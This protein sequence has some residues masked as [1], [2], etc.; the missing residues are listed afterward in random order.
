MSNNLEQIIL[1]LRQ[2]IWRQGGDF[3]ICRD[4]IHTNPEAARAVAMQQ[5]AS[6]LLE[7]LRRQKQITVNKEDLQTGVRAVIH[8]RQASDSRR[9]AYQWRQSSVGTLP[10]TS[11]YVG[12]VYWL[13]KVPASQ[14]ASRAG[15]W[16]PGAARHAGPSVGRPGV[17]WQ[18]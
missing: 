1:A 12:Y 4:C 15:V 16:G 6:V 10:A 13:P 14:E 3:E 17:S 5:V 2:E 7:R 11:S 18:A 8:L 9:S